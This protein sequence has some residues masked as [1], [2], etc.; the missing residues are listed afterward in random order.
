MKKLLTAAV[1]AVLFAGPAFAAPGDLD[2]GFGTGGTG[3]VVTQFGGFL[4]QVENVGMCVQPNGK[5]IVVGGALAGGATDKHF[6]VVRYNAD[7]TLDTEFKS[8]QTTDPEYV[9]SPDGIVITNFTTSTNAYARRCAVG[10]DNKIVVVGTFVNSDNKKRFAIARYDSNGSRDTTFSGNGLEAFAIGGSSANSEARGV[11]I[12]PNGTVWVAGYWENSTSPIHRRVAVVRLAVGACAGGMCLGLDNGFGTNSGGNGRDGSSANPAGS[13]REEAF[14]VAVQADG[15][16]VVGGYVL[17]D[18]RNKFLV[19]RYVSGGCAEGECLDD[20]DEGPFN[21]TNGYIVSNAGSASENIFSIALDSEKI[22]AAGSSI[23]IGASAG[24]PKFIVRRY[25]ANGTADETFGAAGATHVDF[26]LPSYGYALA[27]WNGKIVVSGIECA[28]LAADCQTAIASLNA[29]DGAPDET[30]AIGGHIVSPYPRDTTG[31]T[32]QSDGKIVVAGTS[33]SSPRGFG[34]AR[35]MGFYS[36][37]GGGGGGGGG[38]PSSDLAISMAAV[39]AIGPVLPNQLAYNVTVSNAG[40][41]SAEGVVATITL[42]ANVMFVSASDVCTGSGVTITCN[43]VTIATGASG[44]IEIRV[45]GSTEADMF[46]AASVTSTTTDPNADNNTVSITTARLSSS[47]ADLAIS[48]AA[49]PAVGPVLPNQLAYNVTVSN[50][51]PG[52]ADGVVATVTLPDNVMFIS[53]SDACSR[54]GVTI[55]CSLG[56]VAMGAGSPIE[57]KVTGSTASDMSYTAAVTSA[58]TDPNAANNMVAITTAKLSV[59][60]LP[61]PVVGEGD[62][63]GCTMTNGAG[64]KPNAL[65]ILALA[66]MLS[67]LVIARGLKKRLSLL[68]GVLILMTAAVAEADSPFSFLKNLFRRSVE[69][70]PQQCFRTEQLP[71]GGVIQVPVECSDQDSTR[72]T[73]PSEGETSSGRVRATARPKVYDVARPGMPKGFYQ[74]VFHREKGELELIWHP[75]EIVLTNDCD[76]LTFLGDPKEIFG[77]KIGEKIEAARP[78]GRTG[79]VQLGIINKGGQAGICNCLVSEGA[80]QCPFGGCAGG[81]LNFSSDKLSGLQGSFRGKRGASMDFGMREGSGRGGWRWTTFGESARGDISGFAGAG[82]MGSMMIFTEGCGGGGTSSGCRDLPMPGG[83]GGGGQPNWMSRFTGPQRPGSDAMADGGSSGSDSG[84]GSSPQAPQGQTTTPLSPGQTRYT[85]Y[86][87]DSQGGT[88][89]SSTTV[90][91]NNVSTF[92]TNTDTHCNSEGCTSSTTSGYADTD[93][94]ADRRSYEIQREVSEREQRAK[95]IDAS[96]RAR[97]GSYR[98]ER[99]TMPQCDASGEN[100]TAGSFSIRIK[101]N[102]LEELRRAIGEWASSP[103]H[104]GETVTDCMDPTGESCGGGG[105]GGSQPGVYLTDAMMN[106]TMSSPTGGGVTDPWG[107][108]DPN[109]RVGAGGPGPGGGICAPNSLFWFSVSD[110]TLDCDMLAFG[111]CDNIEAYNRF[112]ESQNPS[113]K[114]TG[115]F[116]EFFEFFRGRD[117]MR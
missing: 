64:Q 61:R 105:G 94:D 88:T 89:I 82:T 109:A 37:P 83:V 107:P 27:V 26:D 67:P 11:A 43:L 17:I 41:D 22:V 25:N 10:P 111:S 110:G 36:P 95:D 8:R 76:V 114:K 51:G 7:G 58:T 13:T 112:L 1:L 117:R 79:S 53:A 23:P 47:S 116:R 84:G 74:P 34:L 42:P 62:G 77:R 66:F 101:T 106:A 5:I 93:S 81:E 100:C 33:T 31:V 29:S 19:A 85:T 99:G 80:D 73:S 9:S 90:I 71:E 60:E 96:S 91:Q 104:A 18:D 102:T 2:T 92:V 72:R 24:N 56:T 12:A 38:S 65:I 40:P 49:V 50:A 70:P 108:D 55:T 32:I 44:S 45:T 63:G 59:S 46:Y 69:P 39:P 57:I 14:A 15:K 103:H 86:T 113:Q 30:F 21:G 48:M 87:R 52:A 20:E 54:S 78:F 68:F 115:T 4:T 75:D 98:R 3:T 6:V 97:E 16:A 35:F 28:P